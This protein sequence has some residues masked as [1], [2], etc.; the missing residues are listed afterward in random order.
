[1]KESGRQNPSI[2]LETFLNLCRKVKSDYVIAGNEVEICNKATNDLLHQIELGPYKDRAR[3]STQLARVRKHRRVYK[4]YVDVYAPLH[5]FV[6]SDEGKVTIRRLEQLLGEIRKTERKINN[7]RVYHP[8]V[9]DNL[10][11]E[12]KGETVCKSN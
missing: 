8:K 9:L 3:F 2:S 6:T 11:I 5:T 10:T 4:D 1:M 7:P 12:N